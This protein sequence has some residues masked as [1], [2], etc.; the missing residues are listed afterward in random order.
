[1][2]KHINNSQGSRLVKPLQTRKVS[3][4]RPP[5]MNYSNPHYAYHNG[6]Q[7]YS[8]NSLKLSKERWERVEGTGY[9]A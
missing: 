6:T 9:K 8:E 3:P 1:M 4:K 5:K 7:F 2:L